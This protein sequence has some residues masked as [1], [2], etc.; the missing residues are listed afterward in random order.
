MCGDILLSYPTLQTKTR[1][2]ETSSCGAADHLS[3]RR[4]SP[5]LKNMCGLCFR[6]SEVASTNLI[7]TLP[8]VNYSGVFFFYFPRKSRRIGD[9]GRFLRHL[10]NEM[11]TAQS[12]F[13]GCFHFG[14]IFED[15]LPHAL[16]VV[17]PFRKKAKHALRR[18]FTEDF[19]VV[20]QQLRRRAS[21]PDSFH[22]CFPGNR[23]CVRSR[24]AGSRVC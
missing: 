22:K 11:Y 17:V 16:K 19:S 5:G 9:R 14:G 10:I 3:I 8:G 1:V 7:S 2:R 4:S 12:L 21:S 6:L 15:S 23:L 24:H 20:G 18:S 13:M